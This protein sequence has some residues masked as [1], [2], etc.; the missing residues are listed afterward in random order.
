MAASAAP[1]SAERQA[2]GG[3][4]SATGNA[5]S[6]PVPS[7]ACRVLGR[8]P[9]R[10]AAGIWRAFGVPCLA[11][12]GSLLGFFFFWGGGIFR[13]SPAGMTS[14]CCSGGRFMGGRVVAAACLLRSARARTVGGKLA[15]VDSAADAPWVLVGLDCDGPG[16]RCPP[17]FHANLKFV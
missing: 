9:A 5:V 13:F 15:S 8:V 7:R 10:A 16:E 6:R 12:V 1:G 4:A 17:G 11:M 14:R 2:R 3:A